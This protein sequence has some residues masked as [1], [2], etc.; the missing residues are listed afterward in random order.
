MQIAAF[1]RSGVG[2]FIIFSNVLQSLA[3]EAGNPVDLVL[4][5]DWQNEG[6]KSVELMA[7]QFPFIK[8]IVKFPSEFDRKKYDKIFMS[9]HSFLGGSSYSYHFGNQQIEVA[10]LPLWAK[11]FYHERDFYFSEL[12]AQ[13]DYRGPVFSQFM[14]MADKLPIELAPEPKI[15]IANGWA[16]SPNGKDKWKR[17]IWPHFPELVETLL[18]FYPDVTVYLVGGKEDQEWAEPV[19]KISNHR[20]IDITGHLTI[21]E[22]AR[23]I[24]ESNL[25]ICNDSLVMHVCDALQKPG[26]ALFG[27]TLVSK[28]GPLNGTMEVVRSGMPCAP[29]QGTLSFVLCSGPDRCM[30]VLPVGWVM[31]VARKLL[32]FS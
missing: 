25:T 5:D 8:N 13:F 21:L 26:I 23:L 3:H 6:R 15:V 9:R 10:K 1:F 31:A 24:Y 12:V 7:R 16:R 2:N 18:G 29:C 22:T 28:N 20:V 30:S 17:K 27:S 4:D 11:H 32:P 14:P 19:G